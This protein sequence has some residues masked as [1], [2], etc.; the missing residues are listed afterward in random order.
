MHD[1]LSVFSN[2]L[3]AYSDFLCRWP[4]ASV[5]KDTKTTAR[6]KTM[7]ITIHSRSFALTDALR[8]HVQ[9]RLG[10]TFSRVRNRVQLIHVRLSDLN[11][12]RGGIDKCCAIKVSITGLPDVVV[13]DIQADM[14]P[15]IDRAAGRAAR[16]VMRRLALD[17]SKR[18]RHTRQQ[19]QRL[20]ATL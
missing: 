10:F 15:A 8:N 18:R 12:P 16:T 3:P 9:T 19:L 17:N 2:V 7:Q 5:L 6:G 1:I 4:G 11:G 14:Y 20:S 13:E